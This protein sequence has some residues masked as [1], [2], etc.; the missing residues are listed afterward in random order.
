[1][2][3]AATAV[4]AVYTQFGLNHR[5]VVV[6]ATGDREPDRSESTGSRRELRSSARQTPCL[7][8][9]QTSAPMSS[10]GIPMVIPVIRVF[11]CVR[12]N[13]GRPRTASRIRHDNETEPF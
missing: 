7:A 8:P 3:R 4:L 1:M 10:A 5:G 9:Y 2:S 12:R 6:D 11:R 13:P